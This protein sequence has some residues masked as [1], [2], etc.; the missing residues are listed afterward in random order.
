M[1]T[2]FLL[3]ALLCLSSLSVM[4]Q[5]PITRNKPKQ[6]ESKPEQ[7]KPAE[8][9][10]YDVDFSCNVS[11]ATMY[12][13]GGSYGQPIGTCFLKT[14]GHQVRVTAFGYADYTTHIE[15]RRSSRSFNF[16]L[17]EMDAQA[18]Y[19]KGREY[20]DRKDY[21]EAVKWYRKSAE[22][23]Y[24]YGQYN[25]GD[26]YENGKGVTQDYAEAAKWY[27]K[28]ADQGHTGAKKGLE[29][30]EKKMAEM[31]TI[32]T[33]TYTP[34]VTTY[35]V[36]GVSFQMVEV[37]GGTFTMGAT[38]EQGSDA[39]D[40]EKPVH[41]VTLSSYS[42]GETEVTQALW[43]AVTG[44]S[45]SQI[46]S[47]NGWDSYG[48]GDSYPMYDVS[49][50]DCQ[51]FIRKL[52]QL[53]GRSFRLPTEA[54]WEYAARGG[55]KSRGYKYSGSNTLDNVAWYGDNSGSKTH[56]VKGKS[57][58]ELGLYDM[59]GNVWEWCWDWFGDYSSSDQ[60]NPTGPTSGDDRVYRGGSF[61]HEAWGCRVSGRNECVPEWSYGNVGFRLAL[62]P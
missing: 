42:I 15:V 28:A 62:V 31:P 51:T 48:I 21:A 36:N 27:K 49:W 60:T 58:N 6:E 41:R 24:M 59:S 46:I 4:G 61:R 54:E 30:M 38:S 53:T 37:E 10:G 19:S 29:R 47:R 23:G 17:K 55:S 8:E 25:L 12:I 32:G 14:G 9:A 44:E 50:D 18:L 2:K 33:S 57:P 56:A 22:Q 45:I 40:D 34:R 52:N 35:T 43:Q 1:R 16:S 3:L 26:C 7:T 39:W 11:T 5:I 13:D 20:Y